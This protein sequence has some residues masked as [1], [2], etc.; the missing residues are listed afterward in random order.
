MLLWLVNNAATIT[1]GVIVAAVLALIV[2]K[3]IRDKRNGK[4]SC[5]CGCGGCP[6]RESCHKEK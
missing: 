4:V 3:M 5:S 2:R 6:M 1:V